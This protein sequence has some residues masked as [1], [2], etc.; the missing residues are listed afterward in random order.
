MMIDSMVTN[1]RELYK[2]LMHFTANGQAIFKT[3][4]RTH[5]K[6]N[7]EESDEE[8]DAQLHIGILEK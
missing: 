2:D 1:D 4:K 8:D 7:R 5:M 3:V 6:V